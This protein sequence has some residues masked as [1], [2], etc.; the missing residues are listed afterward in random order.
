MTPEL[1]KQV[2]TFL[3]SW[4]FDVTDATAP[5]AFV[6]QNTSILVFVVEVKT[7]LDQT[8]TNAT[9]LLASPF[10]SKQ[11]GPKTMEM[12]C[13]FVVEEGTPISTIERWE[14]DLKFCRKIFVTNSRQLDARLSFLQPLNNSLTGSFDIGS[15]FWS[16]METQLKLNEVEL[17]KSLGSTVKTTDELLGLLS[18]KK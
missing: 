3:R 14:Q 18:K 5:F 4:G 7:D 11:F 2:E 17:I 13:V 1:L 8:V 16:Q 6:A 10:R 15:M 9:T 12:Y